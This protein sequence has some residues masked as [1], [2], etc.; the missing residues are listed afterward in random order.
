[1]S[2]EAENANNASN[3]AR[4]IE[5]ENKS[6]LEKLKDEQDRAEQNWIDSTPEQTKETYEAYK[7]AR[8]QY[9]STRTEQVVRANATTLRGFSSEIVTQITKDLTQKVSEITDE[10][11]QQQYIK[12][13]DKG[14]KGNNATR[15]DR[16]KDKIGNNPRMTF[17]NPYSADSIFIKK[18]PK[19]GEPIKTWKD[20]LTPP[21]LKNLINPEKL[22]PFAQELAKKARDNPEY[23]EALRQMKQTQIDVFT[24]G[25]EK[26]ILELTGKTKTEVQS[27]MEKIDNDNNMNEAQ[28]LS[29]KI[30]YGN[31]LLEENL[32]KIKE[33]AGDK[34]ATDWYKWIKLIGVLSAIGFG[35]WA[36]CTVACDLAAAMN[37]CYAYSPQGEKMQTDIVPLGGSE[38]STDGNNSTGQECTKADNCCN[39]C[40][41]C[42]KGRKQNCAKSECCKYERDRFGFPDNK[43]DDDPTKSTRKDYVYKYECYT[44]LGAFN[45]LAED[46]MKNVLN[47]GGIGKILIT[48]AIVIGC[49]IGGYFLIELIL[50]FVRK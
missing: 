43:I 21:F 16:V 17:E 14:G 6:K 34:K 36:A 2:P 27:D 35:I 30:E 32:E 31:K 49:L 7:E 44:G 39:T 47:L 12:R 20:K 10:N 37:G 45:K 13:F 4:K 40:G 28:K 25:V 5:E 22:S 1:M 3:A 42:S 50:S 46:A 26:P 33:T 9:E 15:W 23:A 8:E 41:G 11:V 18:N 29:A 48:A 24:V 38:C 19:T